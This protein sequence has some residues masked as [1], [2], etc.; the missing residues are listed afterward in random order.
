V[1]LRARLTLLC[2]FAVAATV[3]LATTV[4]YFAVRNRLRDQIDDA[5][6]ATATRLAKLGQPEVALPYF[7]L[8]TRNTRDYM[9]V[10]FADGRSE[11][12]PN[13]PTAIP[14]NPDDVAIARGDMRFDF[15]DA[16]VSGV[17]LRIASAP[18]PGGRSVQFAQ[19]VDD[20]D[21]TITD[22]R[23]ALLLIGGASVLVAAFL[24]LVVAR[25]SLRPVARLTRA[26]EHV[27]ETK[28]LAAEIDV[29]RRDELGRLASSINAMLAAVNA[30]RAQQRELVRDAS[31][32]LQTPLT[33]LRTNV[34]VLVE[35]PDMPDTERRGIVADVSQQ[36]LELT[37]L[38]DDLVELARDSDAPTEE[39]TEIDLDRVL[40]AAADRARLRAPDVRIDLDLE[41]TRV[42]GRRQQLERALV[43]VLDNACK[44][45]PPDQGVE[46]RLR[47]GTITVRDH[48]PGIDPADLPRV[49]DR[50][51][52]APSARSMPGSGLG[53]AIAHRVIEGHGG[54]IA[55]EPNPAGGTVA[56]VHL[57][58]I[59][60][61][62]KRDV[63]ITYDGSI[64]AQS[65]S[66]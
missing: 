17:H 51:Y 65:R 6:S 61:T 16:H 54:S 38:M 32:E 56:T 52:R 19:E 48:G 36:V 46:V 49:F 60:V 29:R 14:T 27:A 1:S 12:P 24:A 47:D 64:P 58:T 57:P 50:F 3:V 10:T 8:P 35:R 21:A 30:S 33:S 66:R 40:T 5:V 31:H 37:A 26:A 55:I 22:L 18:A 7:G 20:V 43:N 13:Q 44:W 9:R 62:P 41:P 23:T 34:E 45:S 15:R 59:G 11:A 39:T 63:V 42:H 28:D 2:A 4:S 25:A 53:L